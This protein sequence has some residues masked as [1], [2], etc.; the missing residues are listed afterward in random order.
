VLPALI[1]VI[2]TIWLDVPFVRQ[3]EQGCGAASIAMV[4]QYWSTKGYP[5]EA[6]SM[7]ASQIMHQLHSREAAGIRAQDVKNYL[8]RNGFQA[9]VFS[10]NLQELNDHIEKGRPL[11]AAL[12]VKGKPGKFHYLVVVGIDQKHILVNDP[13]ERKLLRISIEDFEARRAA[14]DSWTLLAVPSGRK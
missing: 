8:D 10:S 14:T 13:S 4:M 1:L 12:E 7:D 6:S 9:F 11:I 2:S 3:T 5:V